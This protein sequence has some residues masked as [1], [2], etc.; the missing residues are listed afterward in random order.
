MRVCLLRVYHRVSFLTA[1]LVGLIC[2]AGCSSSSKQSEPAEEG[3]SVQSGST[4]I[5]KEKKQEKAKKKKKA[6]ANAQISRRNIDWYAPQPKKGNHILRT[7]EELKRVWAAHKGE[8]KQLPKVDFAKEM[9]VAMFLDAGEYQ[10]SPSIT[11]IRKVN[12]E[13]EVSV[14]NT[15]A[16]FPMLNPSVVVA[17]PKDDAKVKFLTK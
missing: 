12:G 2:V 6:K 4:L 3:G 1:L 14:T 13:I 8:D 9:I 15:K 7:A 16:P 17:I 5:P 11:G 10:E